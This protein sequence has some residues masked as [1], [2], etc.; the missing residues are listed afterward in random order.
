M[1]RP[2]SILPKIK[3]LLLRISIVNWHRR[4][5]LIRSISL[6]RG[7]K[8]QVAIC[9]RRRIGVGCRSDEIF[10][11]SIPWQ[12]STATEAE[13]VV[14]L[15]FLAA[16]RADNHRRLLIRTRWPGPL[17][18]GENSCD[19]RNGSS[20]RHSRECRG[21]R[22]EGV[23]LTRAAQALFSRRLRTKQSSR[24]AAVACPGTSSR[25]A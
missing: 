21:K 20:S 10:L 16:A 18:L 4:H 6:L 9:A 15:V 12:L 19:I 25:R 17:W 11:R 14:V 5:C 3:S 23:G 22:R 13:L 24:H 1:P 8:L 7:S 2:A